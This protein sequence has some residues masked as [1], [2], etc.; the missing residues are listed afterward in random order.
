MFD[1]ERNDESLIVDHRLSVFVPIGVF[2]LGDGVT[3][4]AVESL[5]AVGSEYTDPRTSEVYVHTHPDLRVDYRFGTDGGTGIVSGALTGTVPVD[6][7]IDPEAYDSTGPIYA[8]SASRMAV[9]SNSMN[10]PGPAYPRPFVWARPTADSQVTWTRS[11]WG[12]PGAFWLQ[13]V[14]FALIG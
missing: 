8:T 10:G 5:V 2:T 6:P 1:G 14:D 13:S 4:N 12:Q 7:S 3:Q 11:R 9:V